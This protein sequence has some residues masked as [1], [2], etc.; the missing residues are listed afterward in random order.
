MSNELPVMV[1]E[2]LVDRPERDLPRRN[3]LVVAGGAF[4][5]VGGAGALWPF[6]DS[7][8]PAADVRAFATVDVNL[9]AIQPGQR[10]TV[11]WRGWPV[12]VVHR[13]GEEIARA[14]ADESSRALLQPACNAVL[15][16][17]PKW[18]SVVRI[19]TQLGCVHLG[20]ARHD[21][22]SEYGGWFCPC[23]GSK[24]DT[25]G[26]IRRGP[27]PTNLDVP[28]YQFVDNGMVRIG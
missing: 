15:A 2:P 22:K 16:K 4:A 5:A 13:T 26:R 9:A 19:C 24:F 12:F 1:S 23:H 8:N 27:A 11:R 25:S 18:L 21:P 6:F 3:F 20:Q 14:R 10:V 28:P 7:M 17:R